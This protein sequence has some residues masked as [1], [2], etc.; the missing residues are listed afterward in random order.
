[1]PAHSFAGHLKGHL[2]FVLLYLLPITTCCWFSCRENGQISLYEAKHLS[3]PRP[4]Q[5]VRSVCVSVRLCIGVLSMFYMFSLFLSPISVFAT[6]LPCA[7]WEQKCYW[8]GSD[9]SSRY[10]D[11]VSFGRGSV[12]EEVKCDSSLKTITINTSDHISS[13]VTLKLRAFTRPCSTLLF[14][15]H[16]KLL[17]LGFSV[18][19]HHTERRQLIPLIRVWKTALRV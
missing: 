9:R 16:I 8:A 4:D 18:E 11:R 7:S 15:R 13:A 10:Q 19:N 14:L 3:E 2:F 17:S 6:F 12:H 1:M 5:S